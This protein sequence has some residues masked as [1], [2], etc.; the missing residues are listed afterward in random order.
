MLGP[1]GRSEPLADAVGRINGG[2][3]EA[4]AESVPKGLPAD[5]MAKLYAG[6]M[7]ISRGMQRTDATTYAFGAQFVEVRVHARTRE[8]RVRRAVGAF[9]AGRIINP[10][11]AHS[12]FMGGM[13][14][15]ISSA[16]HEA[17]EIDPVL[18][19]YTN[20]NI[21]EYLI[22]VCADIGEIDIIMVPESDD[23][24]NPLGM[25]GIGELGVVGMN[26]AIANAVHHATGTRVRELPIRLDRLIRMDS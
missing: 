13:I 25:K 11:T 4:Y 7:S 18:A 2:L 17:T 26:A 19:R 14:W 8:V 9:A 20:A 5:S 22:P 21:A 12:Q 16:L 6:Q 1:D 10:R 23:T 24:V 15:G 3:V